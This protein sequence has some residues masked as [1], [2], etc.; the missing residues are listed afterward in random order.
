MRLIIKND[1]SEAGEYISQV[2]KKRINDYFLNRKSGDNR[3][4]VMGL[5][6]GSSPLPIYKRLIEMNKNK[7]I[8][9]QEVVTFNMDEYVGL[10]FNHEFSYHYFMWENFFNHIDIKKENINILNGTTNNH[11]NECQLYE[12]KIQSYGG[13]DLFLGGMGVDG[14]IAFNEPGSSLSSRTRIKTLT[15]D[16]IIANSRFFNNINQ[17]PTQALTVG[18][19]T[20]MDAREIIL[21]VTGHSK[22]IALYRTIEEGVNHMWTAS[23]IQ[24]HKKSIIVCDE[25]ATAELKVK[26]Y[27]YF[28]QVES[29]S[30]Y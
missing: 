10:E 16:T 20:I 17:V 7:E 30:N 3:P 11:E 29:N 27:K 14:H 18:V 1:S 8:S 15:R 22:A 5:P 23:A 24:M 2:I 28:K 9:F 4:F 6:T 21:I 19:G 12:E 13:I 26:T 25:D